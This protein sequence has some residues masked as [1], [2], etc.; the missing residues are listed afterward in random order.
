MDKG[1]SSSTLPTR[2][3]VNLIV[4]GESVYQPLP[5]STS[6]KLGAVSF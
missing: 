6:S 5:G 3:I 4:K 2:S 1:K